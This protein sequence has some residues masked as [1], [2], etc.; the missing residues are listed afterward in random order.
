MK[1]LKFFM[2]GIGS[3]FMIFFALLLLPVFLVTNDVDPFEK[4]IS[5]LLKK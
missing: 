5:M 4:L 1:F 2:I 3:N